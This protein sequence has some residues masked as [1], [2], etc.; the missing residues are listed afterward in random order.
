MTNDKNI[1]VRFAPSPSGPLHVG[2]ART[3]LFN[4]LFARHHNGKFILRIEDTDRKRSTRAYEEQ[5]IK[6]LKWL[7]L[8]WDEG[9]GIGGE[10]GPYRQ[11]ER[12][13]T[14]L[15]YIDQL[16][17][18]NKAYLCFCSYEVLE[19]KR[20][21]NLKK[22][23]APK[24]DG[25]CRNLS[26]EEVKQYQSKGIKPAVRFKM[27]EGILS[28]HDLVRGEIT[29]DLNMMGDQVI[30]RSDRN[31]VYNFAVVIDDSLMKISH[32][33]RGEDHLS[34][35]PLQIQLYKALKFPVPKFAH[36]AMVLGPDRSL[37]SK[38][39]GAV[40]L[41]NYRKAGFLPAAMLNFLSLI[42]WSA[43][44]E[45]EIMP[46]KEI[47]QKFSLERVRKGAAVF[48]P[49]K[50]TWMNRHYIRKLSPEEL[51]CLLIPFIKN[52]G[53]EIK[54][55][56]TDWLIEVC[57]TIQPNI[58]TLGQIKNY[59][60]L[61]LAEKIKLSNE[62]RD[63]LKNDSTNKVIKTFQ[64]KI[65]SVEKLDA[66]AYREIV[67]NIS[68]KLNIKGKNL[69][70]PVRVSVTGTIKGPELDKIIVLLG[71]ERVLANIKTI[72]NSI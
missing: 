4:W 16:I 55:R 20:K 26:E 46:V 58:E 29:Y 70:M 32:V 11:S 69:F 63:V 1:Q 22:G 64:E 14:Y 23:I 54:S 50:L 66:S 59:I 57:K 39:H 6:D 34:N 3:A 28:F 43:E 67:S 19:E 53:Y 37:L 25:K 15:E 62:G 42:G 7:G 24:Y 52:C 65:T 13:G 47:I 44:D 60:G 31:T 72:L 27:G 51:Y 18:K 21:L 2:N 38:R 49:V 33:I 71:K 12:S 56:K 48:D 36:L 41:E 30:L 35:T 5:L 17:K 68:K 40:S 9:P 8:E 10:F 61:F 45:K